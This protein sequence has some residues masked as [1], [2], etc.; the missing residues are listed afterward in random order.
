MKFVEPKVILLADTR[1]DSRG[2]SDLLDALGIPEWVTDATSPSESLIE[3]AGRMCYRSFAPGLNPNVTKI[4][5]GNQPY[6]NNI[7][8][9]RHGSVLEHAYVTF[10][11]LDVSRV[12]THEVVR[13][14]LCAF[15]QESLRYVRLTQLSVYRPDAFSKESLLS[16]LQQLFEKPSG[17]DDAENLEE[18]IEKLATDMARTLTEATNSLFSQCEKMQLDLSIMLGLDNT[19]DFGHKKKLTSAL[20]RLV[21]MGITT[22]ILVTTNHRNWRHLIALRTDPAAEEE[23]RKIFREVAEQLQARFL[24]IYQDMKKQENGSFTFAH[25]RV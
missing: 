13:H 14:R 5:E 8:A 4:R 24:N 21:P 17:S 10:A 1:L 3:I 25:G 22:N 7:L 19:H 6:I 15:S 11:F 16:Y 12:F 20:R 18:T 9:S 23:I 2:I